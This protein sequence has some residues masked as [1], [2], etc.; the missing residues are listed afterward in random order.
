M[1]SLSPDFDCSNLLKVEILKYSIVKY[2]IRWKGSTNEEV[3]LAHVDIKST[4][5]TM[6]YGIAT[7][8]LILIIDTAGLTEMMTIVQ[9]PLK[10][11]SSI[12]SEKPLFT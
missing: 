12:E 11:F 6:K 3:T 10:Y 7:E 9:L 1:S 2:L 8:V 5:K 4:D